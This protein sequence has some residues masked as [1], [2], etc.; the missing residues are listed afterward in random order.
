MKIHVKQSQILQAQTI[1]DQMVVRGVDYAVFASGYRSTPLMLAL[2]E[3]SHIK[4]VSHFDERGLAFH[5][6]GYARAT[7]KPAL[8]LTTSGTAVANLYPA[9]VEASMDEVPMIV[10]SSPTGPLYQARVNCSNLLIISKALSRGDPPIAG[11][12]CK[13]FNKVASSTSS[14]KIPLTPEKR[15]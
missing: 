11:V 7:G 4:C 14:F 6:L 2:M 8:I 1:I 15:C 10:L 12:G 5:A 13:T 9:V 3:N